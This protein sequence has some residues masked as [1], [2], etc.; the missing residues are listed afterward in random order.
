M[1]CSVTEWHDIGGA[2]EI[3]EEY[4]NKEARAREQR[5]ALWRLDNDMIVETLGGIGH[6]QDNE[7][8]K[9]KDDKHGVMAAM[10]GHGK[11]KKKK[12]KKGKLLVLPSVPAFLEENEENKETPMVL[13]AVPAFPKLEEEKQEDTLKVLITVPDDV[14]EMMAQGIFDKDKVVATLVPAVLKMG[15]EQ[16]GNFRVLEDEGLTVPKEELQ[17]WVEEAGATIQFF[18]SV[19]KHFGSGSEESSFEVGTS[20]CGPSYSGVL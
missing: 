17:G 4:T 16:E 8:K 13:P 12:E 9:E 11:K 14:Q 20:E 7:E 6:K 10:P 3:D 5:M 19:K 2:E 15:E 1:G 18:N